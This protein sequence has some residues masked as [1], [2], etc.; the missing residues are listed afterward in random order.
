MLLLKHPYEY[1]EEYLYEDVYEDVCE[2]LYR[3]LSCL[4]IRASR[5]VSRVFQTNGVHKKVF[6]QVLAEVFAEASINIFETT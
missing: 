6:V 1:L 3:H 2:H 4:T 5:F